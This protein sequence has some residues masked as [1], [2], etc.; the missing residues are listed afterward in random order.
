MG[1]SPCTCS[2]TSDS[3]AS[4]GRATDHAVQARYDATLLRQL[5]DRTKS[6]SRLQ[7]ELTAQRGRHQ[8]LAEAHAAEKA[9]L[10]AAPPGLTKGQCQLAQL[11]QL[12]EP[13]QET[14]NGTGGATASDSGSFPAG[15]VVPVIASTPGLAR[16]ASS[17]RLGVM[18][19]DMSSVEVSCA[20]SYRASP[21][22]PGPNLD[23]AAILVEDRV[24]RA[25]SDV[26]F[27]TLAEGAPLPGVRLGSP[28]MRQ[29]PSTSTTVAPAATSFSP[30]DIK[31]F[32]RQ[33][34][35][36]GVVSTAAR[37]GPFA[38]AGSRKTA[39][40]ASRE[41]Q[42]AAAPASPSQGTARL[43]GGEVEKWSDTR[44]AVSP[45][46]GTA[47]V[48][49]ERPRADRDALL[50]PKQM[51]DLNTIATPS[52]VAVSHSGFTVPAMSGVSVDSHAVTTPNTFLADTLR[53]STPPFLSLTKT[54]TSMIT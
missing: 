16:T 30:A 1:S 34:P 44:G 9:Q 52:L 19:R 20:T 17:D 31:P 35:T 3:E 11:D 13:L 5:Q 26:V 10:A 27:S 47:A 45:H 4:G 12:L 24:K 28:S 53:P 29:P 49:S 7:R 37:H 2:D 25:H 18:D 14:P 40:K 36:L 48:G 21:T 23:F 46:T 42:A 54:S 41:E 6:L 32:H 39:F 15:H 38:N 8:Q 50:Q 43:K 33:Q 22:L 51:A